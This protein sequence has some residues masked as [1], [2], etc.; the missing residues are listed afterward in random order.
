MQTT[1][2]ESFFR[3]WKICEK[4]EKEV[5]LDY[6]ERVMTVI[7]LVVAV[8][9]KSKPSMMSHVGPFDVPG[10]DYLP[11]M[12]HLHRWDQFY[13]GP[14]ELFNI[15]TTLSLAESGVLWSV[16]NQGRK[17]GKFISISVIQIWYDD[18]LFR[19]SVLFNFVSCFGIYFLE[20]FS[21]FLSFYQ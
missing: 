19:L 12:C 5:D 4:S 18:F 2:N 11:C 10:P 16:E 6:N 15:F 1:V 9:N 17:S 21:C 7:R 20:D 14:I 3:V 13:W 8:S